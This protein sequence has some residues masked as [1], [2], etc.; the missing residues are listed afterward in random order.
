MDLILG[1]LCGI[2]LSL[3]FSFGPAFFSLLQTSIQQGYRRAL[4]FPLGVFASDAIV[5]F[6]ML[7]ILKGVEMTQAVADVCTFFLSLPF[8]VWIS[9]KLKNEA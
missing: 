3:F 4:M 5:V 9:H 2:I 7:T 8:A 1:I 6:L